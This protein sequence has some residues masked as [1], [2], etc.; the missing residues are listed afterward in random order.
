VCVLKDRERNRK[1]EQK[2]SLKVSKF[3]GINLLRYLVV[4]SEK[5]VSRL[6]EK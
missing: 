3:F 6:M 1:K 5:A 2:N 4:R